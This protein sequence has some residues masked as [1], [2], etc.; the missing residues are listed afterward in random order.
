[1]NF[2]LYYGFCFCFSDENPFPENRYIDIYCDKP[3]KY[4]KI[5]RYPLTFNKGIQIE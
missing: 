2:F 1:M 4:E 3:L 5:E